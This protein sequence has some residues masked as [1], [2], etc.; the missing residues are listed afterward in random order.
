M[1][2][3]PTTTSHSNARPDLYA[4]ITALIVEHLE[5]G[6]RP[7]IQ[8]WASGRPVTRPL[9]ACGTPYRGINTLVLWAA[10]MTRGYRS[11]YWLTYRQARELGGY[12]RAGEHGVPVVYAGGLIRSE[13][14]D[15]TGEEIERTIRFLRAY[16]AFNADQIANLPERYRNDAPALLSPEQTIERAERFFA[17]CGARVI[18]G[19]SYACYSPAADQIH[20]PDF[21]AFRAPDLYYSTLAHEHVHWTAHP[22]RLNRP[23]CL[24]PSDASYAGEELIAEL[25]AAYLCADL[26]LN[27]EPRPDHAAYIADW[28]RVLK[29]ETRA[30][31]LAAAQAEK[32]VGY[33]HGVQLVASAI[34]QAVAPAG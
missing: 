15:E 32:A 3:W 31:F 24:H 20:M 25:G 28:L 10:T 12:V 26:G 30:I 23:L 14:D 11:P 29:N 21:T 8:P 33:L 9:R 7:W 13:R 17:A 16:V 19:S 2:D 34:E 1:S 22:S 6:V 5:R 4:R 18:H 27:L